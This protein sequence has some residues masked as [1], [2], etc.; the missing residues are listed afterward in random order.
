[1]TSRPMIRG[2]QW[3]AGVAIYIA[4]SVAVYF[5]FVYGLRQWAFT[6]RDEI[7]ASK[8]IQA[9]I[10]TSILSTDLTDQFR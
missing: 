10:L 1:V 2:M 4:I 7:R 3:L 9:S 8:L 6:M 5:L